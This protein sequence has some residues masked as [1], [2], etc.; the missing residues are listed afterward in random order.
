MRQRQRAV[1]MTALVASR[2]IPNGV[3]DLRDCITN[4]RQQLAGFN[5]PPNVRSRQL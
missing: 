3:S 1:A 5:R 4:R 2:S